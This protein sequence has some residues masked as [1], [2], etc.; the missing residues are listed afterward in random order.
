METSI[1]YCF[2]R[3]TGLFAGS[4]TP[5]IQNKTHDC[6]LIPCHFDQWDIDWGKVFFRNGAWVLEP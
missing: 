6:T 2:K 3:E 4:G 1:Y 5:L